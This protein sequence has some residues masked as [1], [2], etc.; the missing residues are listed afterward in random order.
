M[1]I[2]DDDDDDDDIYFSRRRWKWLPNLPS[3]GL[4]LKTH[5]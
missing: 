3:Q 4:M 5:D 1:F 2:L